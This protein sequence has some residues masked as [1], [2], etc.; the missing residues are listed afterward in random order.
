MHTAE[1]LAIALGEALLSTLGSRGLHV[2]PRRRDR[3]LACRE[4]SC[5]RTWL[6][7][8]GSAVTLSEVFHDDLSAWSSPRHP[9]N[10]GEEAA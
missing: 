10:R 2:S 9:R 4:P 1:T 7:R 3:I 8:A 6:D 5:L